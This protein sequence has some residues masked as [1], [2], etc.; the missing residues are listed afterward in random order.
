MRLEA[1][2]QAGLAEQLLARLLVAH[3]PDLQRDGALVPMVERLDDARL[4]ARAERLEDLV[5]PAD[6]APVDEPLAHRAA[7]PLRR[8]DA[9]VAPQIEVISGVRS[10]G[11]RWRR[12]V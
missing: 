9:T 10:G 3:P 4:A 7:A 6:Q 5:A 12:T 2:Q 11:S 1:E 8:L